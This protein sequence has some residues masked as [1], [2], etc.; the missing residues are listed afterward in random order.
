MKITLRGDLCICIAA[1]V[2]LFAG[3]STSAR[4]ATLCVNPS[5]SNGCQKTI[6]TAV[7][8]ASAG[9]II[10][11]APGTYA[12][13]VTIGQPL[14]LAGADP[15]TTIID[16]TG[17]PNGVFVN[18]IDNPKLSH[19]MISG[20]TV[21]NAKYEGILV[22][23][24]SLVTIA[25]NI[26]TGSNT[27]LTMTAQ[28]ATCPGI[29]VFET[30]EG[31]D[32][33]EAIHLLGTDHVNVLGNTVQN[34][35]GGIL[36]SDDTG[37]TH[38]NVIAGNIVTDN[39]LDC[40]IT[41]A[42]HVPA[43]ITGSAKPLGVFQNVVSGNTSARNG[44]KGEGAGVGIFASAPGTAD[45]ANVVVNNVLTGNG[46]PGVAMHG[47]APGQNLNDNVIVAN[48]ISGNGADTAD[49]STPAPAGINVAGVSPIT[50]TIISQNVITNET[51][52]IAVYAPGDTRIVRNSL[53]GGAWG[54][55][56]LGRGNAINTDWNW[57][58]CNMNPTFP[59]AGLIGCSGVAGNVNVTSWAAA[60]PK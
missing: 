59:M 12:E 7:A 30:G 55:A 2:G 41:L 6:G 38:D 24:A 18:G 32:C 60:S 21:K 11:I 25:N 14:T 58:G 28:G 10:D 26:V 22:A 19:V 50:G 54:V 29:P 51:I 4:A 8:A 44:P 17:L 3:A 20:L 33:G 15:A 47:H 5:G 46:I 49:T 35:A 9:D 36:I 23:N 27:G 16:A 48:Q 40:G 13:S 39:P 52:G 43:A 56:S 45:Y 53:N 37:P 57:W 42:S 34:N 1:A 31:F